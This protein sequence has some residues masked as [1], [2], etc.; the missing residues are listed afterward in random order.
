MKKRLLAI[1]C[2]LSVCLSLV[3]CVFAASSEQQKAADDLYILGLFNGTG[4]LPDG[5]PNFD[6][7]R[8]PTR[9]EA[10]TMLVRLLGAEEEAQSRS[11]NIPFVDVADWARPYVGYAYE[12]R[13]TNGT[14]SNTYSGDEET[15]AAQYL[16]FMLR[17]LK[18]SSSKDF[19]YQNPW[20]LSDEI[21]LTHGEYN[22]STNEFS[23]GDVAV[24]SYSALYT[25]V[26]NT[27][28][29]LGVSLGVLE[30]NDEIMPITYQEFADYSLYKINEKTYVAG[31]TSYWT[32][33]GIKGELYAEFDPEVY[34][35]GSDDLRIEGSLVSMIA[36]AKNQ[37]YI[38]PSNNP[39]VDGTLNLDL[40]SY[41]SNG[42]RISRDEN[43]SSI[44]DYTVTYTYQYNGKSLSTPDHNL[45][46]GEET[47]DGVRFLQDT[48]IGTQNSQVYYVHVNDFLNYFGIN[49]AVDAELVDGVPCLIIE[50]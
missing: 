17:A 8:T 24:I 45:E 44:T 15:T 39:Y 35:Q 30:R 18:Y 6:L 19:S 14:S 29:P 7:D 43:Y 33:I 20:D 47:I 5:S 36:L 11:W 10:V 9:N 42:L 23:R 2:S 13:L 16:T 32:I 25:P 34:I 31:Q 28:V 50:D 41:L 4:T 1:I 38:E 3:P 22:S 27:T 46:N 37:Y 26:K 40:R 48:T 12:N 49:K 21:A